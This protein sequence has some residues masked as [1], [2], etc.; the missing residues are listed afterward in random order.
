MPISTYPAAASNPI[1]R[2]RIARNMQLKEL[3]EAAGISVSALSMAERGAASERVLGAIA[4]A[5]EVPSNK[6]RG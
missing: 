6:L 5:L 1:R 4:K 3:A 2:E